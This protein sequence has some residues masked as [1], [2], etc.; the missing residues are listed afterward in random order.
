MKFDATPPPRENVPDSL[1]PETWVE[2]SPPMMCTLT[3]PPEDWV[4]LV[5]KPPEKTFWVPPDKM[6]AE[7]IY[8][9]LE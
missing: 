9:L 2:V 6:E 7:E 4:T 3:F 1:L 8:W 5:A